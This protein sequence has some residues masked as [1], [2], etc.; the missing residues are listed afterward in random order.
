MKDFVFSVATAGKFRNYS[1]KLTIQL[2]RTKD[3]FELVTCLVEM[4]ILL[5]V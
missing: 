1:G 5:F 4:L 3:Y 2:M